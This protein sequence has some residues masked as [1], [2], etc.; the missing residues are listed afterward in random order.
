MLELDRAR[1]EFVT[2]GPV[3]VNRA[4]VQPGFSWSEDIK[5]LAGTE[6]CQEAH[7]QYVL[8]GDGVIRMDDGTE[9]EIGPHD[10]TVPPGH[11]AWVDGD[12]IT[13]YIEFETAST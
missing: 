8:S 7:I 2:L 3:S 11:D 12:K 6:S 4:Y 1:A 5:P 10:A 9:V 13:V